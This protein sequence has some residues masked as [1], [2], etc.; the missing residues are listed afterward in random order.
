VLE[1]AIGLFRDFNG[2]LFTHQE[3]A[4]LKLKIELSDKIAG[5]PIL[6]S[7]YFML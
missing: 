5:L 1:D 4:F 7:R 3:D 2:G 6:A